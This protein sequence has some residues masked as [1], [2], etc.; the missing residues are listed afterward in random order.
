MSSG[1]LPSHSLIDI[2]VCYHLIFADK[3][4]ILEIKDS[5]CGHCFQELE[6]AKQECQDLKRKL[7][8]C[9]RHLQHLER[10]HRAVVEKIGG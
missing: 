10:K 3:K 4:K 8:K 1:F 2:K 6:N 9:C 7:E 5:C